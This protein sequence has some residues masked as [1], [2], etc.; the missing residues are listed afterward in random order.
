MAYCFGK[1]HKSMSGVPTC[2]NNIDFLRQPCFSSDEMDVDLDADQ[3]DGDDGGIGDDGDKKT[4]QGGDDESIGDNE[5][6]FP[7]FCSYSKP[8]W[9]SQTRFLSRLCVCTCVWVMSKH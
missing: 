1:L 4:T 2:N 3:D 5:G 7:R 8:A 9:S 6:D